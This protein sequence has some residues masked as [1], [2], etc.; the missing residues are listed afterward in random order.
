MNGA[1]AYCCAVRNPMH[2]QKGNPDRALPTAPATASLTTKSNNIMTI[3]TSNSAPNT[4]GPSSIRFTFAALLAGLFLLLGSSPSARAQGTPPSCNG[5]GIGITL[6]TDANDAHIGDTLYYSAY[7]YN[8]IPNSGRTVCDASNITASITTPDGVIHPMTLLRTYLSQ[9]Q[10]DFYSNVVSYVVRAQDVL[11]DGTVRATDQDHAKILQNDTPSDGDGLQGVN[12]EIS[13]PCILLIS[14]CTGGV[15]ENGL[16][17]F[18]GTVTNCG[19]NTLVNVAITNYVDGQAYPVA[20]ITNL[21]FGQIANFSGSFTPTNPCAQTTQTLV[22]TGSDQYTAHPRQLFST[23]QNTC[24]ESLTPGIVVTKSCPVSPVAPGQLLVFSGS[25]SNS[26]NVTLTNIVVVNNVPTNNTP[27]I[28]YATLAPGAISNFTGGY[29][30]PTNC[31]ATDTLTATANSRCGVPV[32]S[33]ATATCSITTTPQILV[34]ALCPVSQILS[35]GTFINTGSVQNTGNN[36]LTNVVVVSSLPVANTVVFSANTMAPGVIANFTTTN[37]VP[38]NAC[39]VSTTFTGTGRDS[40]TLTPVTN[41]STANCSVTTAPSIGVTLSCPVSPATTGGLIVYTGN[42]TNSGNVTLNNIFVVN[43]QPTNNAPVVGPLTLAPHTSSNFTTSFIAPANSCSVSSTVKATGNDNC[44]SLPVTN[45]AT[46]NCTLLTSPSLVLVQTCPVIQAVP[47]GALVYSG[48][49]SNAGNITLTNVVILNNQ[50]GT[51]VI[52]T[53]L[54]MAPGAVSNYSGSYTAPAACSSTSTSTGTAV[55]ICGTPVNNSSTTTCPISTAPFLVLIQNCPVTPAVPGGTLVYSGTVSN[56]GNITVTN[57]IIRNDQTGVNPIFTAASMAPG[58]VSNYSGSYTAP[59]ACTSTSTSTGTATSICGVAMT[60]TV[61]TTCPITTTPGI[62]LTQACPVSPVSPGNLLTFTGTVRNSGNIMLTNVVILN[63]QIGLTPVYTIA[64]LAP[65]AISNYTGSYTAPNSC[66]ST[67]TSTGT[68]T[69]ICGVPVTNTASTTC[70]LTTA[71]GIFLTQ[72]CPVSPV[73]P[74]GLLIY[75][76]SV[77]NSGNITLTNVVILNSQTGT[78]VI[79][80]VTNLPAGAVSNYTGSYLAPSNC[81]VTSTS[82]G[83]GRSTCGI[84]VT[85][86]V[87]STCSITTT[88]VI[89]VTAVCP[90]T[91]LVPGGSFI[92]SGT[93]SNAGNNILTNVLVVADRPVANTVIFSAATMAAGAVANFTSTNTVPAN[94][95]FV[96]TTFTGTG[97]DSCTLNSVT[98][99]A[100]ATCTVITA[101]NIGVTLNCPVTTATT[102]GLITYTGTV[103]NSGN[104]ILNNVTVIDNQASPT[105]VLIIASMAAHSSSNFTA[106]FTAPANSCSVSST[107]TATGSDNCT[108]NMVTNAATANCSLITTPLLVLTQNCPITPAVPGGLLIYSGTVSNAGN[109]TLTNVVILNNQTGTNVI[110]TITNLAPGAVSNYSGSYIAPAACLST[111]TSTGT[112]TSICGVPVTNAVS[113]TCAIST[114]PLLVLTQNCPVTQAVP[115]G[116]LVYSGTVSNAGNITLNN[117]SIVNDQ[118]GGSPIFTAV[119]MAPGA[120]LNY[121]GSYTAPAACSSTSTSTGT[122]TSICGPVV[123]NTATTVCPI[124]TTPSLNL[125]QNC[126]VTPIVP[127]GLLTYT[128][129][130]RN[131]GNIMLTNVVIVNSQSGTIYTVTNLA[132]GAIS[133]YTGSYLT[134]TNCS[135]AST[136]T[137]T[138]TSICG[139]SVTNTASTTCAIT[140]TPVLIV[141]QNCPITPAVPGG[142]LIYSGTVSNA[143]NITLTNVV[144]LN[145]QTGT[146]VI[147]TVTNLAPGAGSNYTGS[148]IAPA[149]CS[150]T[151]TST[152]TATSVCGVSVTNSASTT[153]SISTA[154]FLVLT[155]NCPVT[156]AVPGGLMIY[157]G[158]VSNAGNITITNVVILNNQ[159]GPTPIFTAVS[160]AP[161]AVSNFS[162]SYPTPAACTTTSTS[163]GTATSICG[164]A[165]TNTATTTCTITTTPNITLTQNCPVA[166]VVPGGLLTYSGTVQNTG[167]IMLTN[168]VIVNSQTGTNVIYTVTNL[169]PGA[170]SNYSGSYVAPTNCSTGSTSTGTATSICGVSVTNTASTTCTITTTPVLILTQ[171]CPIT[172]VV[173]GGLLTYSGTVSNAG[174]ITITNVVILNSQTGTNVIYTVT[175]LAPGAVSNY[176]GSYLAPTNCSVTSTSIGTGRSVCGIAVTNT[177]IST[178]SI[179]TAPQIKVTVL[180]PVTP[181][182]PGSV[183]TYTGSVS[184]AGNII[185]TNVLVVSDRPSTNTTVFTLA[186]L[187]PGAVTNFTATYTVPPNACTVTTTFSATGHDNCSGNNVTNITATTCTVI[188]TP[189]IGVTL[190]CP[191][192]SSVT[193]GLITYTGTVTNSGNVILNNVMVIDNQT[194]PTNVLIIASMAAH[195]SSN[196]TATFIAPANSCSVSSTVTATGSDNCTGN[197]VTNIA[198]ANCSLITTPALVLTQNCP[199]SP[200]FPG[201]VMTYSGT[202]SNAGNITIT[203]VVIVNDQSGI[204]PIFTAASLAPGAVSNYSGSYTAPTL[205]S[206]T[207]TSTGTGRSICGVFVTNAVTTTC[208]ITTTPGIQVVQSCPVTN[209]LAGGLLTYTG[210]VRNTGNITL[211]NVIVTSDRPSSNTVIFTRATL[212]VGAIA[213]FSGSY[214]V[215]SNCCVVSSTVTGTGQG[216]AGVTVSD[217]DTR[218]CTVL[219]IPAIVVTKNCTSGTIRAGDMLT[220]TGFVSNSGDITLINVTVINNQPNGGTTLFGPA[221]LAPGERFYYSASYVVPADFCGMDTVTASGMNVCTYH[222]VTNSVTSTCPV[223]TPP[224]RIAL[225]KNCPVTPTPRG[226]LYT[227]TGTVSNPGTVTLV[228]VFIVDNQPTNNSPIIG[229]ISIAPGATVI[230]TNSYIAPRCCCLIFDTLTANGQDRCSGSSVTTTASTVCPIL[231]TPSLSITRVC[232]VTGPVGSTYTYTGFVTNTGD[233]V[234]TNVLIY[235]SQPNANTLLFGPTELAPGESTS[236]TG[237]YTVVTNSNPANDTVTAVGTDTC[238]GRTVSASANCAGAVGEPVPPTIT[239]LTVSNHLATVTWSAISGNTY[240]LQS[241]DYLGTNIWGTVPGPVVATTNSASKL[242]PTPITTN[243]FYRV[244]VGP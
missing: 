135:T 107:V 7:V 91:P 86:T 32:S 159:S 200:I 197:M 16:I 84:A 37:T 193:G 98:N 30:A 218:T 68:A 239:W 72:S 21:A 208:Q 177:V 9:G 42:V 47:G 27:V 45:T 181:I 87:T 141:T 213:N 199:V 61:T 146:N 77:S 28:T 230:F 101:P 110:Y 222:T 122:A 11:P 53:A 212:A 92:Y 3:P 50:T 54:S 102:G 89:A 90:V 79:Y 57:V 169:A 113:T 76:G 20:F 133:N 186:T 78:N 162:G 129:T 180:C 154:P 236:F 183:F 117:V 204:T 26:G 34:T 224:P 164:I 203:N 19:N 33:S 172:P 59:A 202:V 221:T 171:N 192:T 209:V 120:V 160:M 58:A 62:V 67:S 157:S 207:S 235:S 185:L 205:C 23:N 39:T 219:T 196:F 240:S 43:N 176:S 184:N 85:N 188:T 93:V 116:L 152:G 81:S 49:V 17:N 139:V 142:L 168:V 22:G 165:M 56:A 136:S 178:C 195:S 174:N 74:G 115:G 25:V 134:P 130:V 147:Y 227:F 14:T 64:N 237:S 75:T 12:T 150:S 15:G 155:Q 232:P 145:N 179:T 119:S 24:G 82:T 131:S 104:V 63:D 234:L 2:F 124:T 194:S 10:G 18:I 108:G 112:A 206:T 225:T 13:L 99:S 80:M 132:P 94:A 190:N 114:A 70:P 201:T 95:C 128:G 229:P 125:T 105:N 166:P 220:Y 242:D 97:R 148:Y 140:T 65:G 244:K 151:S 137:G 1:M 241:K 226:G 138:A 44:T 187:A 73:S 109:I 36:A 35:G 66:T 143:G 231:S 38:A 100:T 55:S 210:T 144:I 173:P 170:I 69:S 126:P 29:L 111:S 215:P 161:G 60:N 8:G 223:T 191:V 83:T 127:G 216:C 118:T 243:R 198:S 71:P 182:T 167:N 41:S 31:S 211:T 217:T 5:S 121:S 175:N 6:F 88:P 123:S 228:N 52:F 158:T 106:S 153:C 149:A 4:R 233:V 156:P 40:C 46:A 238:Q 163:T 214:Q 189:N 103:T 51:N 96:T 48:T